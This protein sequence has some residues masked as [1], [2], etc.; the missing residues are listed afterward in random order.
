MD[1][2]LQVKGK[3]EEEV[4][5]EAVDLP[6]LEVDLLFFGYLANRRLAGPPGQITTVPT[7]QSTDISSGRDWPVNGDI[8]S[9]FRIVQAV[10]GR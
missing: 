6:D 8:M 1:W 5:H 3:L 7:G 2:L 4:F 9:T 10:A